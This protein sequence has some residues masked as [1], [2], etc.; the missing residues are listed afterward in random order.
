MK[1]TMTKFE[2][3]TGIHFTTKHSGKMEGMV[4][5]ST[6]VK[7][8]HLCNCRK[9]IK[10]SICEHCFAETMNNQYGKSFQDCFIRNT[11]LLTENII[12]V[13]EMPLLNVAF[14]RFESFGDLN[15]DIQVINYFNLCSANKN[16]R[17]ALWTK[18]PGLIAMAIRK[19][20]KKPSNL[21]IGLS[22]MFVNKVADPSRFPFVD[23]VFT[24][25]T[26]EFAAENNV[27]VNCGAKQ[28]LSCLKC[29]KGMNRNKT[30]VYINEILKDE[31]KKYE[32][33]L[34]KKRGLKA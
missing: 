23:F 24:V 5:L 29:Y 31:S 22:S 34:A 4:G 25:F 20:Y 16:T 2:K 18:N 10:G 15:N 28:C 11:K 27:N 14:F 26:A 9:N 30:V 6:S 8:N 7:V 3:E 19:G 32:K 13:S 33:M 1:R 12:P 21:N 17:F